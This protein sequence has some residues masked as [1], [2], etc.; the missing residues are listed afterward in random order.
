MDTTITNE[1]E[2]YR[3]RF[4][5]L[6]RELITFNTDEIKDQ[7]LMK[8]DG[9]ATYTLPD[10]AYHMNKLE[11]GFDLAVNILGADHGAQYKVVQ[12]GVTSLGQDASKIHVIIVQLVRMIRDGKEVKLSTRAGNYETLDDLIDATSIDAVRYGLLARSPN[13]HLDFDMDRAI[14]SNN[15]N[16]VYYIQNAHVRCA[17]IFREA[18]ARGFSDDGALDL[19]LLGA[20]ELA[21]IKKALELPTVI[22]TAA[23]QLE[24]HRIAFYAHELA[25]VF[26]PVYDNVRV[27][28]TEVDPATAKA[29]LRFYRAAQV[30]LKRVL[31]L[32]GMTAPE[33][34]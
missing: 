12:Y 18:A 7:V 11:R 33:I 1:T 20:H 23:T 5:D 10:I 8:S 3:I 34:M 22:E 27:L 13:T 2:R 6:I 25:G 28:H 17:G 16:P 32:M 4:D 24:P 14:A 21:F 29:R 15:D 30:A 19:S 31:D 26:H 9:Q